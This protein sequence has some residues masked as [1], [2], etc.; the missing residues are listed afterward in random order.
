M[1]RPRSARDRSAR[2]RTWAGLIVAILAGVA[3]G[4]ACAQQS[5]ELSWKLP[6]ER[7]D[8]TA[9]PVDELAFTR[10]LCDPGIDEL[11]P[12][13]AES[14]TIYPP[15][16][17]CVV[18]AI[19]TDGLESADSGRGFP[20]WDDP[21][22][23]PAPPGQPVDFDVSVVVLPPSTGPPGGVMPLVVNS[24]RGTSAWGASPASITLPF[25]HTAGNGLLLITRSA[26]GR[27]DPGVTGATLVSE[28]I[29]P[30][31]TRSAYLYIS[32]PSAITTLQVTWSGGLNDGVTLSILEIDG[33]I[34][35]DGVV[36]ESLLLTAGVSRDKRVDID[37]DSVDDVILG[38]A[39]DFF[40]GQPILSD[41]TLHG[42][43]SVIGIAA[44][45]AFPVSFWRDGFPSIDPLEI[46]FSWTVGAGSATGSREV[47]VLR[48]SP[49]AASGTDV[50]AG[51]ATLSVTGQSAGVN[52]A[53]GVAPAAVTLSL[54]PQAATVQADID[55]NVTATTGALSLA[56]QAATVTVNTDVAANVATLSLTGLAAG[57]NAA[58]GVQ[59][60][61]DSLTTATQ[62]ASINAATDIAATVASLSLQGQAA[63]VTALV[64][65][66]VAANTASLSVAGQ[67]AGINAAKGVAAT[68]ASLVTATQAAAV[69]RDTNVQA[70]AGSLT[71]T[72]LEAFAGSGLNVSAGVATLA[73]AGQ[74]ATIAADKA[75]A[76]NT[77]TVSLAGL[78]A[79][80]ATGANTDIAASTA[81]VAL[82]GLSAEISASTQIAC[83]VASLAFQGH[84]ASFAIRVTL[85]KLP[86]LEPSFRD[87]LAQLVP[88][89]G[90]V[91]QGGHAR[92]KVARN[93]V[94]I[95]MAS[96]R[97]DIKMKVN[98]SVFER[99]I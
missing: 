29:T 27:P 34:D 78:S 62:A 81:S 82:T 54:T 96:N 92:F 6:T 98:Q 64:N 43:I 59:A 85:G 63:V 73:L 3:A 21:D 99:M 89:F 88:S 65:T 69:A 95:K 72:P 83:S 77:A 61:T 15:T 38:L 35:P 4:Q 90:F 16:V 70:Q 18:R 97:V 50:S 40:G 84:A 67:T 31:D 42:G 46:G 1:W 13:P 24:G 57:I 76:A 12:V 75:I 91:T 86:Q 30:S 66:E 45:P 33:P 49:P 52:A 10:V 79:A 80:V 48:Y 28:T 11:V 87:L 25:T 41:V 19:D 58:T 94:D 56:G 8:G 68:T 23:E 47:Y 14:W 26:A 44:D 32:N 39:L 55:T 20:I 71:L 5:K 60:N 7:T 53:T 37:P 9:L 2:G 36:F 74:A 17:S 93:R 22:P 51:L